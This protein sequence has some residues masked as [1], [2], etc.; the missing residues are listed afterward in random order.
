[1]STRRRT[2][3]A[4]LEKLG[5]KLTVATARGPTSIPSV[6]TH[7]CFEPVDRSAPDIAGKKIANPIGQTWSGAMMLKHLGYQDVLKPW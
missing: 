5:G 1:M 7:H 3:A 6:N 4:E 2:G